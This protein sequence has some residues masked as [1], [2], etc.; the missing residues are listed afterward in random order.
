MTLFQ[1]HEVKAVLPIGS[2]R[3]IK[4]YYLQQSQKIT[5]SLETSATLSVML[6]KLFYASASPTESIKKFAIERCSESFILLK[7]K[8]YSSPFENF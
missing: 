5:Y 2:T 6:F 1:Q 3:G 8:Q 7:V 4:F